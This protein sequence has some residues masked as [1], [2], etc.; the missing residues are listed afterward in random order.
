MSSITPTAK[1]GRVEFHRQSFN[2]KA[3]YF[4]GSTPF[5][6]VNRVSSAVLYTGTIFF[7]RLGNLLIGW[8]PQFAVPDSGVAS[9]IDIIVGLPVPVQNTP[10]ADTCAG[11]STLGINGVDTAHQ[12]FIELTS[13]STIRINIGVGIVP[14]NAVLSSIHSVFLYFIRA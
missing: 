13:P 2:F 14:L 5:T 12:Y 3:P 8:I 9:P 4:A 6:L 10:G 7:N 1:V 11:G